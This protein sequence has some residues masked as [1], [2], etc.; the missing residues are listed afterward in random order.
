[1]IRHTGAPTNNLPQVLDVNH[2]KMKAIGYTQADADLIDQKSIA[3]FK[4]QFGMDFATGIPSSAIPGLPPGGLVLLQYGAVLVPYANDPVLSGAIYHVA[5]D[6]KFPERGQELDWIV[7]DLGNIVVFLSALGNGSSGVFPGGV[8]KGFAYGNSSNLFYGEY[9]YLKKGGNYSD[10][11]CDCKERLQAE[12]I[13][14]S[15]VRTSSQGQPDVLHKFRVVDKDGNVGLALVLIWIQVNPAN[16]SQLT[17]YIRGVVT[18]DCAAPGNSRIE[19]PVP[20]PDTLPVTPT[21]TPVTPPP[22]ATCESL[23]CSSSSMVTLS[24]VALFVSLLS[25]LI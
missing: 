23:Q 11:N 19:P 8:M 2:T 17:Q 3:Y 12:S 24:L 15:D 25:L 20:C 13:V 9:A 18:F 5:Y 21:P 1:M 6:T 22:P 14:P 16:T 7:R 4:S 10:P